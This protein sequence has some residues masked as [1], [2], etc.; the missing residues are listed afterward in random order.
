ML[1]PCQRVH[2][3]DAICPAGSLHQC[4]RHQLQKIQSEHLDPDEL[5]AVVLVLTLRNVEL[6][7]VREF[8]HQ[9]ED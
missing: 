1:L 7:V 4:D 9:A 2:V 6:N 8:M 3:R 5:R